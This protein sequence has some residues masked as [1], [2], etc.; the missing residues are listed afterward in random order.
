MLSCW[1][2]VCVTCS[3]LRPGGT[4]AYSSSAQPESSSEVEFLWK[5]NMILETVLSIS[6]AISPLHTI[7]HCRKT[8]TD[9]NEKYRCKHVLQIIFPS[10]EC[11]LYCTSCIFSPATITLHL[12]LPISKNIL[13]FYIVKKNHLLWFI[14]CIPHGDQKYT[15]CPHKVLLKQFTKCSINVRTLAEYWNKINWNWLHEN[16]IFPLIYWY[17]GM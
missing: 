16:L 2:E 17:L 13:H 4:Q 1:H 14:S 8:Q 5:S 7:N 3:G 12:N 15:K 11:F 6:R 9:R 10:T